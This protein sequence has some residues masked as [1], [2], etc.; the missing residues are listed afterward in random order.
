MEEELQ[1]F[2]IQLTWKRSAD[3]NQTKL[4]VKRENTLANNKC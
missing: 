3:K 2:P 4:E 1:S